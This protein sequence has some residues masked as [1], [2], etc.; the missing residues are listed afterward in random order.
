MGL[1]SVCLKMIQNIH[2]TSCF[3]KMWARHYQCVMTSSVVNQL[4]A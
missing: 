4:T 2:M 1:T 3:Y